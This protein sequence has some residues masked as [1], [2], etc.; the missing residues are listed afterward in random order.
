IATEPAVAA[1]RRAA[2]QHDFYSVQHVA[3]EALALRGE[4]LP[5]PAIA[6]P[7]RP[8]A[9][10]EASAG[11]P[12]S[13][14]VFIK[15]DN[16]MPNHF[17]NDHW[18]QAYVTT[19]TGPTYRPGRN[20]FVLR[21]ARPDGTVT[22]L[23][24]FKDGYVADCEVSWDGRR[25]LFCRREAKDPWW[26]LYEINADG[27]GL[28]QHTRGPYH[29]VVP[30][31]LADGRIGF[32]SSRI[33]TRDEYHAY[34]STALHVMNP[35]GS[36]MH[37]IAINVGRD[38]EPSILP[39]GRIAF[40]RLEVFYSRLKTELTLHACQPDG[41]ADVVLYGPERRRFWHTLKVGTRGDDHAGNVFA[42]HRV[43]RMSQ[44]QGLPDGRIVCATQ[45][46]LAFI[47]PERT[48]ES[49]IPHDNRRAFTTPWPLP[50]GRILCASTLKAKKKSAVDIGIYLVEPTTGKLTLVYN[51]PKTADY[52]ARPLAARTPPP[53]LPTNAKRN[54][55]TGR[56]LCLTVR[57]T[58][59]AG[60]PR[61]GRLVRLIEGLPVVNRHSTQ[62]NPWEVWKNHGGAIARVLGTVPLAADGSFHIEAPADRLVHFQVLDSDRRVVGNQL[63]WIYTRPGESRS[64]IGCHERPDTTPQLRLRPQA[65]AAE[66]IPLLPT[67]GDEFRYRAKAWL[68]G[69]LPAA[70]EERTRTA[71]AIN[72]LA[73]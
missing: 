18:R 44:P 14:I 71:R 20:L 39:D 24:H 58:Q 49:I 41:T 28:R 46:G 59:E 47:G 43:L 73:R 64:C 27:T 3:R 23:T 68:K 31:F 7:A 61:T 52:E 57:D 48:K 9:R 42:T 62:T 38:N 33:G 37:P 36:D 4:T 45:G 29:D 2:T 22:P 1:L 11:D 17:Q 56:F 65:Q 50:D 34:T 69:A 53:V 72:L 5:E 15:G 8:S 12:L 66:P 6:R 21:P 13:A 25:V 30:F 35:D 67:G 70:V 26:H 60:V 19:D 54:A 63:T 32:A 10:T 51:D 55:Y 40:S 16:A